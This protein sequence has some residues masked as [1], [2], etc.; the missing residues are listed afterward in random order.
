VRDLFEEIEKS[1]ASN[2]VSL[3][4]SLEDFRVL[5]IMRKAEIYLSLAVASAASE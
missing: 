1:D 3:V 2:V 5:F 4:A